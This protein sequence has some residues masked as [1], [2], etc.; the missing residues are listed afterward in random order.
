MFLTSVVSSNR[1]SMRCSLAQAT[2]SQLAG[3][4]FPP[5]VCPHGVNRSLPIDERKGPCN[6]GVILYIAEQSGGVIIPEEYILV[7]V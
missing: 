7:W 4:V 5:K 6:V 1:N 2:I 3:L